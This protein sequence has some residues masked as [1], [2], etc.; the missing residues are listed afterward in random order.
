MQNTRIWAYKRRS[1][2]TCYLVVLN[3]SP[4]ASSWMYPDHGI[5]LTG[6]KLLISN[7]LTCE[8]S[9]TPDMLLLRPFEGRLYELKV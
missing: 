4:G 7:H 6:S 8:A 3:F 2:H 5:N 9:S 1:K